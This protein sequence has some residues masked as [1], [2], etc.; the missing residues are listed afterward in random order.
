MLTMNPTLL[1]GPSDWD[2][3]RMPKE[4]FLH[5][6]SALWRA[7]PSAAGAIVYG[8]RAHHAELAYLTGFTPKLE[9]AL[10]LIPRVGA[11]RLLVGGGV[12][13]LQAA[14]PLTYVD[15]LRPLR[16]AGETVAQWVRE[17]SGGGRCVLI[18]GAF[19]SYPLRAEISEAIAATAGKVEDKT[20]DLW[21]LMRRKS[22]REL[23]AT[24]E[25]CATLDA[26]V[27]AMGKA[28][29]S[30]A[31]ATDAILAGEHVAL[32][33]GAQDVRTLFSSD[34]RRSLRPFEAAAARAVDPLQVYVAVRQFG[35]WADAFAMLT[36]TPSPHVTQ[37]AEVL[38]SAV[39][40]IEPGTRCA[41]VAD[42]IAGGIAPLRAHPVTAR[43]QGNA[44]GLALEEHP[45]I[46]PESEDTF[47]ASGIYSLRVGIADENDHAIVSAM[48]AVQDGG[49]DVLWPA[50][51][52]ETA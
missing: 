14:K 44:I 18:G 3:A 47:E 37:A 38:A 33:R 41:D 50:P 6:I 24:R 7:S 21:T 30:G 28:Q 15:S 26:A 32:T 5:R 31:G 17:Q 22:A 12:N 51:L 20:A 27:T 4:E 49:C 13:M 2:A 9:A 25:A 42:A 48:I 39:A 34:G 45:L 46:A 8:D 40:M 1:V 35:Y 36:A 10:A 23:S 11:P 52:P 43:L 16:N 19:M 29:R